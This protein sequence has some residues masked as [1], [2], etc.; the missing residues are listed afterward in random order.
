[1]IGSI[2]G[3]VLALE[4]IVVLIET[5]DGL[6][7]EVEVPA[8]VLPS[9][10]V[11][12]N[13]FLY[14]HHS[15]REDA[16]LLYGFPSKEARLLF[17][18]VIK[19]SGIGP[20]VA[21]ALLSTFDLTS[22][23]DVINGNRI[24]A[25]VAAPGIGKKTAERIIVEMKD[26]IN[27]LRLSEKISALQEQGSLNVAVATPEDGDNAG[28]E[29]PQN[30]AFS[31]DEAISALISLGYKENVAMTTIKSVFVPGLNT[32]ELIVK[33]LAFINKKR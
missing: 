1:M 14:T 29:H 21:M 15:V 3:K 30:D 11:G 4:G 19:V 26:R 20:R 17:R 31:C 2:R 27:K 33:G 6:G 24:N 16:Q 23:I 10:K 28:K 13:C 9:L 5:N 22:F 8:N 32:Q 12:E 25:L 7:Y 18:E